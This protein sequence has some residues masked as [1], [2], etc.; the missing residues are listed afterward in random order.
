V[1]GRNLAR[2]FYSVRLDSPTFGR[3]RIV[4]RIAAGG[5]GEVYRAVAIGPGG[6]EKPVALKVMK[7]FLSDD[8]AFVRMFEEESKVSFLLVHGNVVQTYDVGKVDDRW[9]IAM[10]LV[11]GTTLDAILDKC[12]T[13]EQPLPHRHA[14]YVAVEALRGLDY[15]QNAKDA[16]GRA[17]GVVHR[18]ISPGN[19]F[20]SH[21]GEVKVGDFGIALSSLGARHTMAGTVKGKIAYMSP[22]QCKGEPLD[23]R[24]DVY[25]MGVV[26][27]EAL[28]L[29]R[30]FKGSGP[31]TIPSILAGQFPRP[32]EIAPEIPVT[33]EAIVL[34]AM[35]VD[36]A[37]RPATAEAF[38]ESLEELA[39]RAGWTMSSS[40]FADFVEKLGGAPPA[41]EKEDRFLELTLG[42][43]IERVDEKQF[44]TKIARPAPRPGPTPPRE[45]VAAAPSRSKRG[46]G[47]A[48]AAG[49]VLV[50]AGA[51]IATSSSPSEPVP[52][53][54]MTSA[55]A[56]QTDSPQPGTAEPVP[57]SALVETAAPV[58][59]A[60]ATALPARDPWSADVPPDLAS[61]RTEI[62]AG[63]T[64]RWRD[65]M[66]YAV[67][68]KDP[69]GFLLAGHAYFLREWHRNALDNYAIALEGGERGTVTGDPTLRGDPELLDHLIVLLRSGAYRAQ[70]SGLIE[71]IWGAEA[72]G[73]LRTAA[74]RTDDPE[75]AAAARTLADRLPAIA[76]P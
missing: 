3:Y 52:A 56:P 53:A 50:V 11:D 20:V 18:D 58:S 35:S 60:P 34:S 44:S 23:G 42:T 27:Y 21:S 68:T 14:I 12:R 8:P 72:V 33:L 9:F 16:R 24:V 26:L 1:L 5:M 43:E 10:E 75:L 22:E 36:R 45:P 41:P 55:S 70:V 13:L 31:E 37:E 71:R 49:A 65:V 59:A 48:I 19:L 61:L 64:T 51:W 28:T 25:A 57:G 15:A 4:G 17:L 2:P 46:R 40:A 76:S 47:A 32:R 30:P 74:A 67:G 6:V 73:A 7:P 29:A 62:E 63:N 38:L 66:R 54:P 69:R 39:L